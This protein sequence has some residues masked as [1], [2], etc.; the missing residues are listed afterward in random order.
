M[1][2]LHELNSRAQEAAA[3]PEHAELEMGDESALAGDGPA[4]KKVKLSNEAAKKGVNVNKS[5]EN[6]KSVGLA[7][8]MSRT[9]GLDVKGNQHDELCQ[10]TTCAAQNAG[11]AQI[12]VDIES[13]RAS[14]TVKKR[15]V[16]YGKG[17]RLG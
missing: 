2:D 9:T 6:K 7:K 1:E 10:C 5:I 14:R 15:W 3:N 4:R 17:Q 12:K 8:R 16:S 11:E 13:P